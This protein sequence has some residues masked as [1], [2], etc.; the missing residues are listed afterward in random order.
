MAATG[1]K[2]NHA[3]MTAA[4]FD[5]R[6]FLAARHRAGTEVLIPAGTRIAFGGGLDFNDH[7]RI[8]AALDRTFAKHPDMVLLHGGSPKGA[9]RIAACWDEARGVTQIAF[10]PNWNKHAKAARSGE[11]T[12]CFPLCQSASSFFR[13]LASLRNFETRPAPL[14]LPAGN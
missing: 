6:D 3:N 8:W 5:S 4:M 1:S 13:G 7:D 2:V 11:T 9:E 10:K 12:I 14:E